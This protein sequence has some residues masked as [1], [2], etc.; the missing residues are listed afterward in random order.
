MA[1]TADRIDL[2]TEVADIREALAEL[3]ERFAR[4]M[5]DVRRL[6]G[7][8]WLYQRVDAYP[9]VR[10]DRDMG[11][12]QDADAWLA[13]GGTFLEGDEEPTTIGLPCAPR[14]PCSTRALSRCQA[15]HAVGGVV[16][17]AVGLPSVL[18][19]ATARAA[20]GDPA[21][22]AQLHGSA[23][24]GPDTAATCLTLD[25]LACMLVDIPSSVSDVGAPVY[26]PPV[27]C[28][29]GQT[30][31]PDRMSL[32]KRRVLA[33][34]SSRYGATDAAEA[35]DESRAPAQDGPDDHCGL[36]RGERGIHRE[37][38][39][40]ETTEA[41]HL[42]DDPDRHDEHRNQPDQARST[43]KRPGQSKDRSHDDGEQRPHPDGATDPGQTYVRPVARKHPER[44]VPDD[45]GDE[46]DRARDGTRQRPADQPPAHNSE[47]RPCRT[48][49]QDHARRPPQP[50]LLE[51]SG[52]DVDPGSRDPE[53]HP[54]PHHG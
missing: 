6:P 39:A 3:Q 19:T 38:L 13:E 30:I 5:G 2:A 26:S 44:V 23:R 54:E 53:C 28:P 50:I 9:G 8:D 49:V 46:G 41:D 25:T 17:A 12:G 37:C 48:R 35:D 47:G 14:H 15:P 42:D 51:P 24:S 34:E 4:L 22:R 43:D 33:A 52:S 29:L 27:L 1:T 36:G 10:L 18:G 11:A 7:G 20:G 31:K 45:R 21:D 16:P 40:A 32:S